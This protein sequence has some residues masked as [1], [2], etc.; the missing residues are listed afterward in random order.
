MLRII[1]TTIDENGKVRLN[2]PIRVSRRSRALLMIF[3]VPVVDEVTLMSE[4]A[5]ADWNR[6][7]EDAAWV[8]LTGLPAMDEEDS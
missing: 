7:E 6:P 5:L 2:E 4:P 3:D 1:E 8:H